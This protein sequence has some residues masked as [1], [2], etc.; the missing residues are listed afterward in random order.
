MDKTHAKTNKA[1]FAALAQRYLRGFAEQARKPIDPA[2]LYSWQGLMVWDQ[3]KAIDYYHAN[4]SAMTLF[5]GR[6]GGL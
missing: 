2:A 6:D 3:L 4:P 5:V 1:A